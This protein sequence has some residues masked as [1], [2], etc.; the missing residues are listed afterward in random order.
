MNY[1]NDTIPT[2]KYKHFKGNEYVVMDIGYHS[3]TSEAMVIYYDCNDPSKIWIRP[4]SMWNE[5]VK[6]DG[7]E[8]PRFIRV[9]E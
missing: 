4:L 3:E 9:T 6:R 1:C 8:G 5:T 7:Y 2:G